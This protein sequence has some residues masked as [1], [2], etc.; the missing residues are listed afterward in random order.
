MSTNLPPPSVAQGRLCIVL[1][2]LLWSTSGMF[3]KVLTQATFLGANE[4]PLDPL[5]LAG[6]DL[7]VQMACYRALFAGLVLVPLLR[8]PDISFRPL[9]LVM[10]LAFTTMNALFITALALGTAANAI[11]LQYTAPLW[12]YLA[13]VFLLGEKAE[14]GGMAT[15]LLGL[16]GIGIIVGGGWGEGQ[17]VISLIALG[18]GLAYAGVM[19]C[20]RLLRE[21]SSRW[22]TAWNHLC[23]GLVLTPLLFFVFA[24]TPLQYAVLFL[25]GAV[26]MA[27]PYWLVAR[28]LRSVSPQEAGAITLLEPLLNPLWAYLVSPGTEQPPPTTFIG[29]GLIVAGLVWR[30]WPTRNA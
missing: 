6:L 5:P 7:P 23:S 8:R 11:L 30:Y 3:A 10:A 15:L 4:P 25:Y 24:P 28:G 2:A 19:I 17:G 29:G 13:S 9:M 26:Q 16:A 27:L 21:V 12:M 14:R 22:L 1:A 18:A 20:L